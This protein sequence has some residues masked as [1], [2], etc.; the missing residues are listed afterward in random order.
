MEDKDM[1][2]LILLL[3][4]AGAGAAAYYFLIR[5]RM[6]AAAELPSGGEQLYGRQISQV[7]EPLPQ[8]PIEQPIESLPR[9]QPRASVGASTNTSSQQTFD[10]QTRLVWFYGEM[11]KNR[12]F[13]MAKSGLVRLKVGASGKPD[14]KWGPNSQAALNSFARLF[15]Y[16]DASGA[17]ANTF[18]GH[19]AA[20]APTVKSGFTFTNI[21]VGGKLAQGLIS[22]KTP[23]TPYDST[24]FVAAVKRM[25]APSDAAKAQAAADKSDAGAAKAAADANKPPAPVVE[26]SSSLMTSYGIATKKL[27]N[28]MASQ[29]SAASINVMTATNF[30]DLSAR[31]QCMKWCC[32]LNKAYA[33]YQNARPDDKEDCKFLPKLFMAVTE[34]GSKPNMAQLKKFMEAFSATVQNP[35][36]P[37]TSC[38]K[39]FILGAIP[40]YKSAY[41]SWSSGL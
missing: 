7:I 9:E 11:T 19:V 12:T 29:L 4:L 33:D 37:L 36:A 10:L 18:V 25:P 21:D 23:L 22:W 2:K 14:G 31:Q 5:P 38:D 16:V 20:A 30:S 8:T 1:T 24:A 15:T 13:D 40:K 41:S 27:Y 34:R 32:L 17:P 6:A 3:G 39:N 28:A 35:N 26:V